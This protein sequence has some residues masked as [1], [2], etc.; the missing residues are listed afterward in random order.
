MEYIVVCTK[1]SNGNLKVEANSEK[2][3]LKN[4]QEMI[5]RDVDNVDWEFGEATADFVLK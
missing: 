2:E 1:I 3:A 5:M 4:A